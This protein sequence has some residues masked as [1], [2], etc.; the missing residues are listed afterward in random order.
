L[1][2][3]AEESNSAVNRF[4]SPELSGIGHVLRFQTL[5]IRRP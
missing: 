1:R 4:D 2:T 3:C 5:K